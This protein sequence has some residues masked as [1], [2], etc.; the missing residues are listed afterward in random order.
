M[1]VLSSELTGNVRFWP[2]L[3]ENPKSIPQ[4]GKSKLIHGF[5]IKH[6]GFMN[7]AQWYSRSFIYRHPSF[8]EVQ[9]VFTQARP[10]PAIRHNQSRGA[11]ARS[12]RLFTGCDF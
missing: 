1:N 12:K 5:S 8:N 2:R 10:L 6:V 7:P 9:K 11:G 4:S 3:C